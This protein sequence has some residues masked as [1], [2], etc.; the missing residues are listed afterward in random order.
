LA[1]LIARALSRFPRQAHL[2]QLCSGPRTEPFDRTVMSGLTLT[3]GVW[4][5]AVRCDS[6][7]L[8]DGPV[9]FLPVF[10]L[11][12]GLLAVPFAIAVYWAAR[13]TRRL[14]IPV[15][16][17]SVAAALVTATFRPGNLIAMAFPT[18]L[19]PALIVL[20]TAEPITRRLHRQRMAAPSAGNRAS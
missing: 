8:G 1:L 17:L 14:T 12:V 20:W 10:T 11:G 9:P 6:A 13:R 19:L 15:G 3:I 16:V 7:N 18:V 2:V 4:I 5:L